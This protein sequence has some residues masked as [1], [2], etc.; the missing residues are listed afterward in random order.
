MNTSAVLEQREMIRRLRVERDVFD[1]VVVE[2]ERRR[3]QTERNIEALTA[4][5]RMVS[6]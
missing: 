1:A 6:R 5:L 2:F 4:A 3:D